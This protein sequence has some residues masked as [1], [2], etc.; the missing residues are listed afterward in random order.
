MHT[1]AASPNPKRAIVLGGGGVTGIAWEVGLLTGLLEAGLPL[2]A[3]TA[4][5]GTSAEAFV[6]VALASDHGLPRLFAAQAAPSPAEVAATPPATLF[7]AWGEAFSQGG[8]DRQRVG[9]AFGTIAKANPAPV[10]AAQRQ[11]AVA[12]RLVTQ[13]WPAT[14]HI[15]AL[16]ADTGALHLFDRTS[17]VTLTEAVTASGAVPGVWPL[18]T[19]LGRP[20]V[21]GGMVSSTNLLLAQAYE[22]VLVLAPLPQGYGAMPGAAA[23]AQTLRATAA[24]LLLTPDAESQTAIG[25]NIY[26]PARRGDTAAAGRQQGLRVAAEVRALWGD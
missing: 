24:V 18:V 14:L 15:T 23:D 4:I 20:W 16:D 22:R 13:Q 11:A 5:I 25:P 3:A 8:A 9:Q 7:K 1:P 19:L 2:P 6:G 17:G 26:D 21:D 10:P 12:S